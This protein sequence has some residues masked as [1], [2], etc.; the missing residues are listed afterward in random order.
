[1]H[2]IHTAKQL[3]LRAQQI[4]LAF[5]AL[6]TCAT[7]NAESFSAAVEGYSGDMSDVTVILQNRSDLRTTNPGSDGVF[8]FDGLEAGDYFVKV[9]VSGFRTT[10]ARQITVPVTNAIEPF[11]LERIIGDGFSFHWEEDQTTSGLEY[12]SR[13]N[14]PPTIE[15]L[16]RVVEIVDTKQS[17]SL[18]SRYNVFLSDEEETWTSE[19]SHRLHEMLAI[20][21]ASEWA[22]SRDPDSR[23][24]YSRWSL[25][26]EELADDIEVVKHDD[27]SKDVRI[28]DAAFTNA[29]PKIVEI[30]GRRG[31]WYSQR[32]HHAVVRYVTDFGH[33][34]REVSRIL[35][36]RYGIQLSPDFEELTAH[37]TGDTRSS[38]QDFHAIEFVHL[39][40]LMEEMPKGFHKIP[41][42]RY[43]VR[44]IDGVPHPNYPA[45]PAVA[46]PDQGYIEFME[47]A[48]TQASVSD[49]HRL[50]LHEKAHFIW[51]H[52]LDEQTKTDWIE[53][54]EWYEDRSTNSGWS[55]H[56]T[57][58][59]VSAYAHLKNPNE[60]LAES[61]ADFVVNPDVLTA[62][63]PA[64]YEFIRD[65]LMAGNFYIS[66]IREDLT[67]E[68]Y[69]LFPD[70]TYPGKV[71]SIDI[72]VDGAPDEDKTL[73]IRVELHALDTQ[74]ETAAN[75]LVRIASDIGTFFDM[76]LH[77]VDENGNRIRQGL[78]LVGTKRISKYSKAG[79]WYPVQIRLR[80]DAG[81]LRYQRDNTFD[82]KVFVDNPREDYFAP[83]YVSNSI[84]LENRVETRHFSGTDR[85][86][87]VINVSWEFEED[88]KLRSSWPCYVRMIVNMENTGSY[89][90]YGKQVDNRCSVDF[91]MPHYMP[92][93]EYSVRYLLMRDAALNKG[94][95]TFVSDGTE[96]VPSIELMTKN[97][98]SS[99]PELDVNRIY[100]EAEPT[101]I[102]NP[103]GETRV[104]I[105]Y[106]I[107]DDN[108]GLFDTGVTL[109]DPQGGTRFR[110][111]QVPDR[112]ALFSSAAPNTWQ[113]LTLIWLLPKGSPPGTW[114]IESMLTQDKA[115]NEKR[116]SFT[117]TIRIDVENGA[118]VMM[119][120]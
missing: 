97:P 51:A 38:F 68:V 27:G 36:D 106:H 83:K 54:G 39:I 62:R 20:T 5:C 96:R 81:N 41:E 85:E 95:Y 113:E 58:Q 116:Y 114:G 66:K 2:D 13:I 21:S 69:N 117:E 50:I 45:A 24:P 26:S 99:P 1:M 10:P 32:L 63:A 92:S 44:R 82:M 74:E 6:V 100:V 49:I 37:T 31:I 93:G 67:F 86:I 34:K 90:E 78:R 52:V 59:F 17:G 91:E 22:Y 25:V 75:L 12:A 87:Q 105:T 112:S 46:W 89:D 53:L 80:D 33:D 56:Q 65:R 18:L 111:H 109:R 9:Q 48:F 15:F 102:D 43:V 84:R 108:S 70:Y 57:T 4:L 28:A 120:E 118:T 16:G 103:D 115:S 11:V 29:S 77:P 101:N 73:K 72:Q 35:R 107:R 47:S 104:R 42:L 79:Y 60:D 119:I 76:Y 98:D 19:H 3:G 94:R 71:K 64:K 23:G 14:E 8:T 61:I 7:A 88:S 30:D 55:T 40:N 110:W